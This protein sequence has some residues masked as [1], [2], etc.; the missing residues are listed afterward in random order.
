MLSIVRNTGA[1][2]I[3]DVPVG[4]GRFVPLYDKLGFQMIGFDISDEMLGQADAHANSGVHLAVADI[5]QL[6]LRGEESDAA[7][8][9]RLTHLVSRPTVK[10]AVREFARVIR[11]GGFLIVSARLHGWDPGLAWGTRVRFALARAYT[12]LRFTIGKANSHSHRRRWFD[13]TLRRNGL[14]VLDR[15]HVNRTSIGAQYEILLLQAVPLTERVR[16]PVSIELFGLPGAGKTTLFRALVDQPTVQ[17]SDGFSEMREQSV[18]SCV[19]ARPIASIRLLI[20]LVPHWRELSNTATKKVTVIALRQL[21]AQARHRAPVCLF[22]EG[23]SHEAWRQLIMGGEMSDKLLAKLLPVADLTI[24]VE[25]PTEVVKGRLE[26][27]RSPGPVSRQLIEEDVGGALW[28]RSI[29]NYAR[30]RDAITSG[31]GRTVTLPNHGDLEHGV[32]LLTQILIDSQSR[33]NR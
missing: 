21:V 18:R 4:T 17:F 8:C 1:L 10:A 9:I 11:P 13:R 6:P 3:L 28:E 19:R 24:L 14:L 32:K 12:L 26:M 31:G 23:A 16:R 2:E 5:R 30:V 29:S 20:R 27:K 15:Q 25:A 33:P 22:Q 7:V